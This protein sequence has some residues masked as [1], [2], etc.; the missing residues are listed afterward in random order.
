MALQNERTAYEKNHDGRVT[1]STAGI[2]TRPAKGQSNAR[3]TLRLTY[4]LIVTT[5]SNVSA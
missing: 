2:S 3:K 1:K 5:D 4:M